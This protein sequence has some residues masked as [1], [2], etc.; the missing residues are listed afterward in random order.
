MTTMAIELT[1]EFTRALALM[2]D[3][4]KHLFITGKAGTGKSTLLEHFKK[5]TT[6]NIAVLAPTGVAAV[7]VSGQTI[8]SFFQFK[9]AVLPEH[10][11]KISGKFNSMRETYKNLEALVVDEISMVRADLLDCMDK[12][13]R[14][15]GPDTRLPF[16]GVQMILFGDLYQL[17]PVVTPQDREILAEKYNSPYFFDAHVF[18]CLTLEVIELTRIFRQQ[19]DTFISILNAIRT[20]NVSDDHLVTLNNRYARLLDQVG[21]YTLTLTTTNALADTVNSEKL[22]QL[23]GKK[24]TYEGNFSGNFLPKDAPTA[25]ELSLKIGSQI[26]LLNN[27]SARRWVNGS[28]GKLTAI[29]QKDDEPDELV[30]ELPGKIKVNVVPHTWEAHSFKL[31]PETKKV[32]AHTDGSFTQYP[33]K[34]AWA[35]TIHKSQGKTF[36]QVVIDL[37]RGTFAHGQLYVALSRC[38][39][40]EGIVL[41]QPINPRHVIMDERVRA[42]MHQFATQTSYR[43]EQA[44]DIPRQLTF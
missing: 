5:N 33:L 23:K 38:R 9:P 27:D 7:N 24:V 21:D 31:D 19:D 37:G 4:N 39:S 30:V 40:L 10:I 17:P 3:S 12:F 8:H 11:Q 41:K 20:N 14:L 18:S 32:E 26:M 43:G 16:G 42:F 13:L 1:S 35:V 34:L 6:K 2:E 25:E 28:I 15:N 44:V 36:D 29:K 22:N